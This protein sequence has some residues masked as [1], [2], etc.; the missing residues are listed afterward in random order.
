MTR[1][2]NAQLAVRLFHQI[3]DERGHTASDAWKAVARL[4]LSCEIWRD[5][6]RRPFHGVVVHRES[7]DFKVRNGRPSAAIR[8]A[9]RLS[10]FLAGE[11]GCPRDSVCGEISRFW[12]EPS[13]APLQPN[14]L[15]GNAFRS[16]IAESLARFGNREIRYEEECDPRA[17]YPGAHFATRSANPKIDIVGFRGTTPVALI[18]AR[19]R[20]RHDRV[21]IP[22]EAIAYSTAARRVFPGT[23]FYGVIAEFSGARI[24]KVLK[25]APPAHP[26]PSIS[27]VVHLEPRL[28]SEGL[29]ENGRIAHLKSLAWL[30]AETASW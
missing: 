16:L 19:W 10:S 30:I 11:L 14:N 17:L 15:V 21:D 26:N 29:G 5:G 7:N 25:H 28:V 22:D 9:E 20:F 3:C 1:D 2:P 6:E 24:E 12:R 18:S 8:D 4:L 13:V 23:R 27:A